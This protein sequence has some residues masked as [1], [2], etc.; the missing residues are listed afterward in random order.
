MEKATEEKGQRKRASVVNN[1][2]T[3][4]FGTNVVRICL[5]NANHCIVAVKH[6]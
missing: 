6:R 3:E 4:Y 5:F 1:Q 2:M